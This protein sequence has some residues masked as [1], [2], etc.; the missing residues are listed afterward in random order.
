MFFYTVLLFFNTGSILCAVS[1]SAYLFLPSKIAAVWFGEKERAT[2]TSIA[3]SSD[4]LGLALSYFVPTSIV[5]NRPNLEAIGDDIGILLLIAAVQ[6]SVSFLFICVSVEDQPLTPPS[7]SESQ[8]R[9]RSKFSNCIELNEISS[10]DS[11]DMN[12]QFSGFTRQPNVGGISGYKL[13]LKNINFHTILN[14]HGILFGIESVFLISLNELLITKFPG[15]EREIGWMASIGLLLS[16]PTTFLLG[17]LIDRTRAFKRVTVATT[18]LCSVFTGLLVLFFYRNASFYVLSITYLAIV[19]TFSTY[20]TT[21]FDHCAE[22]TYPVSEAKSGVIL[23][24]VAQVYSL[25]LEQLA[26]WTLLYV[27]PDEV[28]YSVLA[29]YCVIFMLSFFV[30]DKGPRPSTDD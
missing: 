9:I 11:P 13:L 25:I 2:A 14:I 4:G 7:Y 17:I 6:A 5:K 28:L 15:Y 3:V 27:G 26:S 12:L 29:L 10:R 19:A 1:T 22:L 23:M 16:I 20:Y 18:G 8:K 21:A 24:W 30:K